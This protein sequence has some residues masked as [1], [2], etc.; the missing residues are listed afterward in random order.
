MCRWFNQPTIKQLVFVSDRHYKGEIKTPR[1]REAAF[2]PQMVPKGKTR[3]EGFED[4]ILSLYA[5]GMTTMD[6]Q[7]TIKD[8]YHGAEISHS[9]IANVTNAVI[10][11]VTASL[12]TISGHYCRSQLL[13]LREWNEAHLISSRK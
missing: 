11:E 5:Q 9:V 13:D 12:M 6:I 2:N 4:N 7:E 8:L 3:L 10:D 1:D